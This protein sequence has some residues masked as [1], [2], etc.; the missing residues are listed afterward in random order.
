MGENRPTISIRHKY[1]SK[2]VGQL[3]CRW[4]CL[5]RKWMCTSFI[6]LVGLYPV[7]IQSSLLICVQQASISTQVNSSSRGQ[8]VCAL[9]LLAMGR[10]CY[11]GWAV[12]WALPCSFSYYKVT[13]F[14]EKA[15]VV[16]CVVRVN[17]SE[18]VRCTHAAWMCYN[19]AAPF[20]A[21]SQAWAL[22][23]TSRTSFC[24]LDF[25]IA[26]L[27]TLPGILWSES[28]TFL[29]NCISKVSVH[30]MSTLHIC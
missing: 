17:C 9:L 8:H 26:D 6:N 14:D 28:F 1:I 27:E 5:K 13:W 25:N 18:Q 4:A 19:I 3:K 16:D 22:L 10:H 7:L 11:A 12:Q 29:C 30:Y 15:A 20:Y 24:G 23:P 2:C 21:S